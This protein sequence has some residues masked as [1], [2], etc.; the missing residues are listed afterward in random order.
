MPSEDDDSMTGNKMTMYGYPFMIAYGAKNN[1]MLMARQTVMRMDMTMMGNSS[2]ETGLGDLF[3][4]AKYK[5]Y[6]INTPTYTVGV[7]PTLGISIPTGDDLFTSDTWDLN[8]GLYFTGR[9]GRLSSH[10]N[11]AYLWFDFIGGSD[12]TVQP[13]DEFSIDL[14]G[15]YQHGISPD[16]AFAPVLEVSYNKIAQGSINGF[17]DPDSGSDILYI[18]PGAKFTRSSLVLEALVRVPVSQSYNGSQME[19]E[20]GFIAGVRV[21]F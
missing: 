17:D 4:L 8:A 20:T 5:A 19:A 18:S 1:L 9:R 16:I 15:A 7:S 12:K 13:G 3:L 11:L 14:A 6:R 2:S 10:L 21:M